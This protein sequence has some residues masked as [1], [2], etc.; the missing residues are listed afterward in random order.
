MTCRPFAANRSAT[1]S[2]CTFRSPC[3]VMVAY[4]TMFSAKEGV[5]LVFCVVAGAGLGVVGGVEGA[6]VLGLEAA[7][8][9]VKRVGAG[10]A[11]CS[12]WAFSFS[13]HLKETAGWSPSQL[14]HFSV[15]AEHCVWV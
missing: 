13:G 9:K 12:F 10:G 4:V 1:I 7:W 2:D 8:A 3:A 5:V 6:G 15:V 11:F 14:R